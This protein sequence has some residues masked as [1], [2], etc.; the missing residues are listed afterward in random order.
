PNNF[1]A[2]EFLPNEISGT[3]LYEPGE[4]QRENQFKELLKNR[5]KNRYDY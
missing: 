3:K 4:N 2:Q 1:I 5:W